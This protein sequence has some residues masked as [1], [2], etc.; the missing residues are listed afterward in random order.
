MEKERDTTLEKGL[1]KR[2]KRSTGTPHGLVDA[3]RN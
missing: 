2:G 3:S 1:K